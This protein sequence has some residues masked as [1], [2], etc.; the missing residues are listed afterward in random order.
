MRVQYSLFACLI[1][2]FVRFV[3]VL[4]KMPLGLS[5]DGGVMDITAVAEEGSGVDGVE[6]RSA[7]VVCWTQP[8]QY[9]WTHHVQLCFR[10]YCSASSCHVAKK[11]S[12]AYKGLGM[13][14]VAMGVLHTIVEC[15]GAPVANAV[16]NGLIEGGDDTN[17]SSLTLLSGNVEGGAGGGGAHLSICSALAHLV[18]RLLHRCLCIASWRRIHL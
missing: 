2:S 7:I 16:R 17:L 5:H 1:L 11:E 12:I 4:R 3:Y 10:R 8:I 15:V 14:C 13:A 9:G 18:C 6:E